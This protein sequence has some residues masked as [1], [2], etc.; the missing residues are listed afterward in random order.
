MMRQ[1]NE[2]WA[3]VREDRK[4][5]KELKQIVEEVDK[6]KKE[7]ASGKRPKNEMKAKF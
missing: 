3:E 1:K 7:E 2:E 4:T 5:I 6:T